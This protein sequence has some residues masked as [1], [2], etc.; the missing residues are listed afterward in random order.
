MVSSSQRGKAPTV[1]RQSGVHQPMQARSAGT[2][3]RIVEA[4]RVLLDERNF[5][6]ISISEIMDRAGMSTGA[7]Y[8]RFRNKDALLPYLYERYDEELERITSGFL[9]PARWTGLTLAKRVRLLVRFSVQTYRTHRGLWR[10]VLIRA[11]SDPSMVTERRRQRRRKLVRNILD[12]LLECRQEVFHPDPDTAA[13]FAVILLFATCKDQ[14]LL[15][16]RSHGTARISGRQLEE[17]LTRSL[18]AYLGVRG[19]S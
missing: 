7:F 14:I 4:A 6:D 18:I 13:E 11:S 12:L 19:T 5:D 17:Q 16:D 2:L 10:A 3:R 9:E 8:T 1:V 15:E